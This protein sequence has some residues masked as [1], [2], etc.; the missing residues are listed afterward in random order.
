VRGTESGAGATF[1]GGLS[2]V[3]EELNP[4]EEVSITFS[5]VVRGY[6]KGGVGENVVYVNGK[7]YKTVFKVEIPKREVSLSKSGFVIAK[8]IIKF[9]ITV[10][11][12]TGVTT[13]LIDILPPI[14]QPLGVSSKGGKLEW[15]VVVPRKGTT[16]VE[17]KMRVPSEYTGQITNVATLPEFNKVSGVT[18]LLHRGMAAP[19]VERI[20]EVAVPPAVLLPL[21]LLLFPILLRRRYRR[22]VVLD[23][24]TLKETIINIGVSGLRDLGRAVI[25]DLTLMKSLAD[26]SIAPI[27]TQSINEGVLDVVPL[28]DVSSLF[29]LMEVPESELDAEKMSSIILARNFGGRMYTSSMRMELIASS[30]GVEV[31]R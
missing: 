20:L 14:G 30:Y 24:E 15:T 7:P 9:V 25:S 6:P 19:E 31:V 26:P 22:P 2:W 10:S 12:P 16:V 21:A 11:S 3:I 17:F 1:L 4:G 18:L 23:Y 27:V 29:L 5:A 28:D 13:K 8:G